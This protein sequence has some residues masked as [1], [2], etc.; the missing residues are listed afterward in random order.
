M[1]L[2]ATPFAV[3]PAMG[4]WRTRKSLGR[5]DKKARYA[6]VVSIR[7]PEADVDLYNAV[8]TQVPVPQTVET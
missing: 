3:Y 2:R 6:L 8:L 4:W 5:Y 1:G 7:A